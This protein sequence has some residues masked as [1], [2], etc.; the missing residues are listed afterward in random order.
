MKSLT[1][2]DK[3]YLLKKIKLFASLD[4]D[5]LLP[6]AD[7]LNQAHFDQKKVIF[8]WGDQAHRM[9]L[10]AKGSVD[11]LDKEGKIVVSL[12]PL[13]FFGDESLFNNQPRAYSAR[14]QTEAIILS[15]SRTNLMTIISECPSIAISLLEVYTSRNPLREQ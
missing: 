7:K 13:D 2:I 5:E 15:I 4:L 6:V 11:L 10:I 3:A 1:L 8:S 12:E 9:Y 14:S